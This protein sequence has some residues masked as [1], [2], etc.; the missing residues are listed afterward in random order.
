M[1]GGA[2][3]R[4][5][6]AVVRPRTNGGRRRPMRAGARDADLTERPLA[7]HA[8]CSASVTRNG[9]LGNRH[10]V[11]SR[12]PVAADASPGWEPAPHAAR[13]AGP[14][15]IAWPPAPVAGWSIRWPSTRS[16]PGVDPA[17]AARNCSSFGHES[18]R[19]RALAVGLPPKWS[20]PYWLETTAWG[21][22]TTNGCWL[23][24][25]A[26]RTSGSPNAEA[27]PKRVW[28][29]THERGSPPDAFSGRVRRLRRPAPPWRTSSQLSPSREGWSRGRTSR[30]CH[31][32]RPARPGRLR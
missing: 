23:S 6:L 21:D 29:G 16:L 27:G 10:G 3:A 8:S 2:R 4:P 25:T 17:A 26:A 30:S 14:S 15:A 18:A 1:T 11:K 19:A 24:T 20:S 32:R 12:S 28:A 5:P 13:G 9:P 22:P 31:R 7:A